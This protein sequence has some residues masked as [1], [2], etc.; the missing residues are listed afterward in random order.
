MIIADEAVN[1]NVNENVNE[2]SLIFFFFLLF[3][4]SCLFFHVFMTY[5]KCCSSSQY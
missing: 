1:A 4:I 2:F 5:I 3:N